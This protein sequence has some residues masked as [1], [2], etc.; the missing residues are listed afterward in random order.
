MER[1]E[2]KRMKEE[3]VANKKGRIN[4]GKRYDRGS[5]QHSITW[6]RAN[7]PG[8]AVFDSPPSNVTA[9]KGHHARLPCR[10]KNLGHKD[11]STD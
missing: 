6:G 5:P 11:V 3:E 7:T 1:K 9:V 10:V 4:H 2:G 8:S